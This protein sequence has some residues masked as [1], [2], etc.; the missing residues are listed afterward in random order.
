[1]S[2]A[3]PQYLNQAACQSHVAVPRGDGRLFEWRG[4]P[5]CSGVSSRRHTERRS[6]S[7]LM[8]AGALGVVLGHAG[9]MPCEATVP[10]AA[11]GEVAASGDQPVAEGSFA[12]GSAMDPETAMA[13]FSVVESWIR[14]WRHPDAADLPAGVSGRVRG[15]SVTLRYMG[16]VVG[17][18]TRGDADAGVDGDGHA[19][20]AAARAAWIEAADRL[21][22]DKDAVR[23]D[24][25]REMAAGL[26]ISVE[27]HGSLVPIAV[28]SY[29]EV[30]RVVSPGLDGVAVRIG[31]RVES[32]FP[33]TMLSR[34]MLPGEALSSCVSQAAG[35]PTLGIRLN[36]LTQP[37]AISKSHGAVF[38]RFR[39]MHVAQT[40]EGGPGRFLH[41]GGRV[42]SPR[43]LTRTG[44]ES[45]AD[46]MANRLVRS[47]TAHPADVTDPPHPE[48]DGRICLRLPGVAWPAT[49]KFDPEWATD[50]TVAM[51]A[52]A[53]VR[54]A[55][56]REHAD[57]AAAHAARNAA[58][59]LVRGISEHTPAG[60]PSP[61]TD[62]A[63]IARSVAYLDL[64]PDLTYEQT[65]N[66]WHSR[67]GDSA[68]SRWDP[69]HR[70]GRLAPLETGSA[71][72]SVSWNSR[73]RLAYALARSED[74]R[75]ADHVRD[76]Y[77][78]LTISGL[79]QA[80]PWTAW[81]DV[82][83]ADK[84]GPDD[85]RVLSTAALLREWRD[86][87]YARMIA[88]PGPGDDDADLAGGFLWGGNDRLPG[89]GAAAS[90]AFLAT[91]IP[92]ERL[93]DPADRPRELARLLSALR[94]LRQLTVDEYSAYS[95]ADPSGVM[96]AVRRSPVDQRLDTEDT[97]MTLL[98][99]AEAMVAIDRLARK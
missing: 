20:V 23:E 32:M 1:M 60:A 19:L 9:V 78:G 92:D 44:L 35:D 25:L 96:G 88:S 77:R 15:A 27:V 45:W 51:A 72:R 31:E 50:S 75:A 63:L 90:V 4:A 52:V 22:G 55:R 94:F 62:E 89:P 73:G 93:T 36:P 99:V 11:K 2:C 91:M 49:G 80:M 37:P 76:I 17:R 59:R 48:A 21:P 67:H 57:P 81:A 33:G 87:A 69:R 71:S 16:Q 13:A 56:A 29:D 64:L 42:I 41:R 82:V 28:L 18:G 83:I 8:A 84:P 14:P 58:V 3:N 6:W 79:H 38:Y 86:A 85:V 26:M 66:G 61:D 10:E 74:P 54:Y 65:Y 30:D 97:A 46:A 53:L 43:D 95:A 24:R 47:S 12:P 7:T 34:N 70:L 5:I 40:T 39:S 98:A 68:V